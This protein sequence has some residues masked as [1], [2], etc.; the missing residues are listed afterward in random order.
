[1]VVTAIIEAVHALGSG[2]VNYIISWPMCIFDNDMPVDEAGAVIM[3][4]EG[5]AKGE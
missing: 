1:M 4:T 2:A 3:T 5:R